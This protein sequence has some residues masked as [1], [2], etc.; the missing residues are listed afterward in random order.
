[1]PSNRSR[2]L[3]AA[4]ALAG[5]SVTSAWAAAGDSDPQ[6]HPVLF[7][8]SAGSVL[9]GTGGSAAALRQLPV[10]ADRDLAR[11]SDDRQIQI[12]REGTVR[13][14]RDGANSGDLRRIGVH[15]NQTVL[16]SGR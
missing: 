13:R 2:V 16:V 7:Q 11:H 4:C 14:T 5:I 12:V 15:D 3:V 8:A 6:Q 10:R 1:M 9:T